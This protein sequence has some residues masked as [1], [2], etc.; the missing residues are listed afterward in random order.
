MAS[1]ESPL[2]YFLFVSFLRDPI[3]VKILVAILATRLAGLLNTCSE[4]MTIKSRDTFVTSYMVI[5]GGAL[6]PQSKFGGSS[7]SSPL[8]P[9]LHT[10]TNTQLH[11]HTLRDT[12]IHTH[13]HTQAYT[14]THTHK[15]MG[16]KQTHTFRHHSMFIPMVIQ[17]NHGD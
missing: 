1:S 5:I 17:C 4:T 13:K 15:H 3:S 10:R 6:H 2:D 11:A 12:H 9:P 16:T 8:Q 14:H 7:P